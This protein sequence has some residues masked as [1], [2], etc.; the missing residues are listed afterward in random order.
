MARF[1]SG[2]PGA[3]KWSASESGQR[4]LH[5]YARPNP[6]R[7]PT[8]D[9]WNLSIQRS[10]TP[11]LSVTMAYVGNKGTH[12]L[13]AGDGNNTNPNESGIFLPAQYSVNG[14]ALHY[15]T[16]A[17]EGSATPD[18]W[19]STPTIGTN[20]AT[21]LQRYYGG[22]LAACSDP[23]YAPPVPGCLR[24]PA[25]GIPIST[26]TATT[27]HPLQCSADQCGKAIYQGSDVQRQ[28]CMA[29]LR[30]LPEHLYDVAQSGRQGPGRV[31]AR[32]T[33]SW[34]TAATNCPSAGIISLRPTFPVFVD[35]MIGGWQIS[36]V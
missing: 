35:E 27:G 21:L 19:A 28:L 16:Q 2:D 4:S 30:Q 1:A 3:G 17:A 26:T 15:T 8:I 34:P 22:K 25:G 6:L 36:P 29:A 12:T 5:R 24:E 11:T 23:N 9:A 31:P 7:L 13:S 10:I 32:A 20:N 33:D 18:R 14:Q